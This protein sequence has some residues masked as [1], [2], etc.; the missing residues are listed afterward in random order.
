M[1]TFARFV[2]RRPVAHDGARCY[3]VTGSTQVFELDITRVVGSVSKVRP[4]EKCCS[5]RQVTRWA[6]VDFW[7]AWNTSSCKGKNSSK[8]VTDV[9][10]NGVDVHDRKWTMW[11]DWWDWHT[12]RKDIGKVCYYGHG[13]QSNGRNSNGEGTGIWKQTASRKSNCWI[14]ENKDTKSGKKERSKQKHVGR[15]QWAGHVD[16]NG[17]EQLAKKA[18]DSGIKRRWVLWV[19]HKKEIRGIWRR[20]LQHNSN[21]SDCGLG[22]PLATDTGK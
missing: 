8:Y 20:D 7:K 9:N 18:D 4:F 22:S 17:K 15:M 10:A 2:N 16:R 5:V 12:S 1:L 11:C 13:D 14:K 6:T 3:H 21:I 19:Q